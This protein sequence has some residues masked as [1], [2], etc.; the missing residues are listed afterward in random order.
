[1][2]MPWATKLW[3]KHSRQFPGKKNWYMTMKKNGKYRFTLQFGMNS[4]QQIRAGEILEK[5]GNK[6]SKF[7]IAAINEY[8]SNHPELNIGH[9]NRSHNMVSFPMDLLEIK[10]REILKHDIPASETTEPKPIATCSDT[11][12][13]NLISMLDDLDLF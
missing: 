3:L 2:P 1:M 7:L 6:K 4:E 13:P 11:L 5:M 12:D 10:I 8:A 9:D